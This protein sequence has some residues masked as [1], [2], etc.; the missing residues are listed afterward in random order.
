M[1]RR[2]PKA[3]AD[4]AGLHLQLPMRNGTGDPGGARRKA[5]VTAH[6]C[7]PGGA[8]PPTRQ[9]RWGAEAAVRGHPRE[10]N[11]IRSPR[12]VDDV[13]ICG[14]LLSWGAHRRPRCDAG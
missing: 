11:M 12:L 14:R 4:V 10:A 5:L 13:D 3:V 2:T 9:P 8:G 1:N 6:A 7:A